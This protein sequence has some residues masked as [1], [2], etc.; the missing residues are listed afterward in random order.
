MTA[1]LVRAY[2]EYADLASYLAGY[3]ITGRAPRGV[4]GALDHADRASTTR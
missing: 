2:T 1:D 4:V 3:A